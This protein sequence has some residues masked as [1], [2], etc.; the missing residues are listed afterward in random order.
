MTEDALSPDE[1]D[2]LIADTTTLNEDSKSDI[3]SESF[4]ENIE[5]ANNEKKEET[6]KASVSVSNNKD[7][8]QLKNI[9]LLLDIYMQITV[10]LGKTKT[11]V[12][13]ILGWCEGTVIEL[14]K[15]ATDPV[16]LLVNKRLVARGEVVVIDENFGVRITEIIDPRERLLALA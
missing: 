5:E 13:E 8:Q 2:A 14:E 15:P 11:K 6:E 3:A 12:K 4:T 1:V 7:D 16:S 9:Q 10:E